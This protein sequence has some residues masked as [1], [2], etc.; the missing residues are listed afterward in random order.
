[1]LAT[2]LLVVELLAGMQRY[3]SQTI[4]PLVA[5]E[6]DGARLY[7]VLDAAAQAPMFL[8]MPLGAW[9]LSRHSIGRLML[10]LTLLTVV[11]A[12]VCALAPTMPVFIA[13]T[14]IRALASGALATVGMGA[15]S[16][17]LPTRYRQLVLAGM[18]G[19]WVISSVIGPVYAVAVSSLLGW[20]WAIVLYL[21]LLLL[22][23][24]MIAR[25]L[26]ERTEEAPAEAAPWTW[27]IV[28]AT[29]ALLLSLPVGVW[30]AAAVVAGGALMLWATVA[31]LPRRHLHGVPRPPR[32]VVGPARHRCRV[33]RC[34]DGALGRGPRRVRSRHR[35]VRV[36]HRRARLHVGGRRPVVRLPPRGRRCVPA[37]GPAR[38]RRH[39]RGCR[40]VAGDH[41]ARRHRRVGA[42]RAAAR[43]GDPR[44]GDGIALPRP[45]GSVPDAAPAR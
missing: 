22:A 27:A 12:V 34:L 28:L 9:L 16:R 41:A 43:R 40:D 42:R 1:M 31:L 38:R 20:R 39:R 37:S 33:L 2:S 30:S 44:P 36:R 14:A 24:M 19:V 45:P 29:G 23:R 10:S 25:Y 35:A 7:G 26:P 15:I 17:G 32:R 3:L 11:G 8:T 18:S 5:S 4:V 13:G 6:L 21:P